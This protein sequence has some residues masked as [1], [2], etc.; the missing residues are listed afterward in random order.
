MKIRITTVSALIGATLL[1][2]VPGFSHHSNVAFEVT[3]VITVTGVVRDF[4]WVNPH[5]WIYLKVDDGKGGTV[6]WKCEG[7]AP[8]VLSRAGWT[9][10]SVKPGDTVTIDMSPAKDGSKTSLIARV[11]KSDGTILPNAPPPTQ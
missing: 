9:R 11:T 6:E 5:T 4:D 1:T 10:H 8:G 7:R 3:K 2:A